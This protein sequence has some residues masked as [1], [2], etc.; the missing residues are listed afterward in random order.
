M[1]A[2][3]VSVILQFGFAG[4]LLVFLAMINRQF[5][6]LLTALDTHLGR[7]MTMLEKCVDE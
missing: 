7:L 4:V 1:D 5:N 2:N 3:T 6:A